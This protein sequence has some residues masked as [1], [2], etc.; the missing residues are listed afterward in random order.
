MNS[1]IRP[2]FAAV[3]FAA[4]L[5]APAAHAALIVTSPTGAS[6][7]GQRNDPVSPSMA[8]SDDGSGPEVDLA[9]I[10]AWDFRLEWDPAVLMLTEADSYMDFNSQHLS[11]PDLVDYLNNLD[12]DPLSIEASAIHNSS[13][14]TYDLRFIAADDQ[15]LN[16]PN[17]GNFFVLDLGAGYTF[18]SGFTITGTAPYGVTYI[19]FDNDS[20]AVPLSSSLADASLLSEFL[21]DD[22]TDVATPASRMQVNVLASTP[23]GVPEPGVLGLLLAGLGVLG[24]ARMRRESVC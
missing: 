3:L 9:N 11:L 12:G 15:N 2:L 19:G 1:P 23:T 7:S 4:V 20:G 5:I 21:Y 18:T 24:G 16:S 14:G 6:V 17:F 8:V 13:I 22:V 10:V